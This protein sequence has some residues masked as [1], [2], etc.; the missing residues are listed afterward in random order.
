M[1]QAMRILKLLLCAGALVGAAACLREHGE[2]RTVALD[3]LRSADAALS[4]AVADKNLEGIL[5]SYA[6]DASILPVAEPIVTG[7]QAIRAEWEH[8][9]AIPGYRSTSTAVEVEVSRAGDLGYTRG[10][11][12]ATFD[13]SDGTTATERGKWVSVWK[14]QADGTWRVAVEIYNTDE[15]PPAHQ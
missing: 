12:A 15:P 5:Q 14:K 9:L 6:A 7:T 4:K 8:I 13:L 2:R 10:T 11:Y 3:A 1:Y